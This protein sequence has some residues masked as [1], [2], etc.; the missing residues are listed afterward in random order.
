VRARLTGASVGRLSE[1]VV[2][3]NGAS[4]ANAQK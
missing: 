3:P 2:D 1:F 4:A